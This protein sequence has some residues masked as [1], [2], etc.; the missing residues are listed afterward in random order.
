M[1]KKPNP[2]CID[3]DAPEWSAAD[4]NTA[5]RLSEMPADF[6]HVIRRA[7]GPQKTPRKVQT[8]VRYDADIIEAFKAEGPG[9]QTRMNEALRDW[10]RM[11][12]RV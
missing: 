3:D 10:L 9:W 11:H 1:T 8:A 7:R 12:H 4:F 6:Q 2:T 5:K